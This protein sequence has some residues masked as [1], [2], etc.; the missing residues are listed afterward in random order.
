MFKQITFPAVIWERESELLSSP[1]EGGVLQNHRKNDQGRFVQKLHN[2]KQLR[3]DR[4]FK[5]VSVAFHSRGRLK[6]T[7][8]FRFFFGRF[9]VT[10]II[11][12]PRFPFCSILHRLFHARDSKSIDLEP[13]N[14]LIFF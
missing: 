14:S 11:K 12:R 4:L 9:T 6:T 2:I 10:V 5:N 7:A 13:K 1:L 3:N 8:Y